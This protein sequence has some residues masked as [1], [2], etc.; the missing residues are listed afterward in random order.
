[1]I[2]TIRRIPCVFPIHVMFSGDEDEAVGLPEDVFYT[3][4]D[5]WRTVMTYDC[6]MVRTGVAQV[7]FGCHLKRPFVEEEIF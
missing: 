2:Y 6:N 7:L 4:V 1:M 5:D 3:W